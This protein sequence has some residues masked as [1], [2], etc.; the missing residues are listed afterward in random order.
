MAGCHQD[1]LPDT[2]SSPVSLMLPTR[3]A[4]HTLITPQTKGAVSSSPGRG[5]ERLPPWQKPVCMAP[6]KNSWRLCTC[7]QQGTNRKVTV[8]EQT[9]QQ[10]H[11]D[12]GVSSQSNQLDAREQRSV[13]GHKPAQRPTVCSG[14][15][16]CPTRWVSLQSL[17]SLQYGH[18][19]L[20]CALGEATD[21]QEHGKTTVEDESISLQWGSTKHTMG[22]ATFSPNRMRAPTLTCT[23]SPGRN[24]TVTDKRETTESY[25][26]KRQESWVQVPKGTGT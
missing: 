23:G 10:S 13:C 25:V 4:A 7:A 26:S 21:M 6:G 17:L 19:F 1:S 14:L 22:P 5:G 24:S 16:S 3:G 15:A 2:A 12:R 20:V 11:T 8:E 9:L 18:E